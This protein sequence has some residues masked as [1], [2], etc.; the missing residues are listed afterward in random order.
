VPEMLMSSD[1]DR[2]EEINPFTG[3]CSNPAKFDRCVRKV[4]AKGGVDNP[5]AVCNASMKHG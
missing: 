5:Y 4:K 3:F 1:F 2:I